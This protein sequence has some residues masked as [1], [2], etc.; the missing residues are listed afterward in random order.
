MPQPGS[1]SRTTDFKSL[2]KMRMHQNVSKA[3]QLRILSDNNGDEGI[4]IPL[5][6]CPSLSGAQPVLIRP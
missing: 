5:A 4:T 6:L 1:H 2:E 3:T